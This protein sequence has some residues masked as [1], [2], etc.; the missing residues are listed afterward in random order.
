MMD[1]KSFITLRKTPLSP[2]QYTPFPSFYERER[3]ECFSTVAEK[4][5]NPCRAQGKNPPGVLLQ[6]SLRERLI[7]AASS[8][9]HPNKQVSGK[10]DAEGWI[11]VRSNGL[12]GGLSSSNSFLLYGPG[13]FFS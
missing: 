1:F 3:K 5:K 6:V 4:Q 9:Q 12:V 7:A 13:R 2:R 10:R 11:R 8:G